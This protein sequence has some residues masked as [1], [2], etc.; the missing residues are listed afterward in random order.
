MNPFGN[1]TY[2][3]KVIK[4]ALRPVEAIGNAYKVQGENYEYAVDNYNKAQTLLS[5]I[6]V[7]DKTSHVVEGAQKVYI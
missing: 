2:N 1:L 5:T 7:D 6:P 4:P 3:D